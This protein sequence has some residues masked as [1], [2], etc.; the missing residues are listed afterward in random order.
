MNIPRLPTIALLALSLVASALAQTPAVEA[1]A[2]A[3]QAGKALLQEQKA[4]EAVAEF[5]KAIKLDATNPDYHADLGSA[6]SRLMPEANFI[7]KA[8]LSGKMLKAFERAVELNPQHL[9]GLIG[10]TR[11]YSN[12]P[13]IAGGSMEKAAATATRVKAI[14]PFLGELEFANIAERNDDFAA[15]LA[16]YTAAARIN[17]QHAGARHGSGRML[18]QLAKPDEARAEFAAALALKPD[19]D[20]ARKALAALDAAPAPKN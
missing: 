18:V 13:E 3:H 2:A 14:H 6:I 17:P 10:L 11:Y 19:F 20:A 8:M 15:A 12:A 1:A 5:E 7:Q 4:K 9:G 16:H